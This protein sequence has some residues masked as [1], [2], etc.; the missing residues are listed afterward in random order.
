MPG[1]LHPLLTGNIYHIYNKTIENKAVF[2][3]KYC[4]KFIQTARYYRSSQSI[5]RFSNFQ[6]LPSMLLNY[7]LK[8]VSDKKTF[9]VTI[10]AYCLMP[11]HYHMLIRQNQDKGISFFVSQLQNSFTRFYNLKLLRTGP[12]MLEKFKSKPITSE[13]QLKHVSRYIHLNPYSGKLVKNINNIKNYPYS[14][15][16]EYFKSTE[17]NILSDPSIILSLFN[18]NRKKYEEFVLNNAQH[19]KT[20]EHCKHSNKW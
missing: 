14:S 20:L 11:T 16:S 5:F 9:R 10:L 13:E 2:V 19:Q 1:R 8:K 12:V 18:K 4:N 17:D 7:Y 6:K 15:F 3:E